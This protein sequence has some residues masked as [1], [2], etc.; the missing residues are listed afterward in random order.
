MATLD[1]PKSPSEFVETTLRTC[2]EADR[3]FMENVNDRYL[4]EAHSHTA[5]NAYIA[6]MA[7]EMLRRRN[8]DVANALAEHLDDVFTRGDLGGP[9]YRTAHALGHDPDQWIAEHEE[10]AARRKATASSTSTPSPEATR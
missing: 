3:L 6:T 4:R 10:R 1:T 2:I 9:A 7:M 5:I 8:P